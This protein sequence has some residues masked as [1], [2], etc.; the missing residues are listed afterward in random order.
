[1]QTKAKPKSDDDDAVDILCSQRSQSADCSTNT[2]TL[3]DMT[4][5]K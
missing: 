4:Y 1:L 2:A 5:A 3:D